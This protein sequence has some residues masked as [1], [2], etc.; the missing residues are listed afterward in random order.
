MSFE[1]QFKIEQHKARCASFVSSNQAT[2]EYSKMALRG[3]FLLNAGCVIPIIYSKVTYLYPSA[4]M[5]AIGA[6]CAAIASGAAYISQSLITM[7]WNDD[8][9][10]TLFEAPYS[11]S[12]KVGRAQISRKTIDYFRAVPI[13]CILTAYLFFALGL[14]K[15]WDFQFSPETTIEKTHNMSHQKQ[16]TTSLEKESTK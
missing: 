13:A 16:K 15:A 14:A 10:K 12:Y 5:F 11:V 9:F 2:V 8:L 6:L 1:E 3:A 4:R 7:T